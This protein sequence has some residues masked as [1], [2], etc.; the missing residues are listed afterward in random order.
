MLRIKLIGAIRLSLPRPNA[1][2]RPSACS[3]RDF[4]PL[5]RHGTQQS[6]R[7]L[8]GNE[9]DKE[10]AALHTRLADFLTS[11]DFAD[12]LVPEATPANQGARHFS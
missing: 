10:W 5:L 6:E 12:W 9:V 11:V 4:V 3:I 2:L 1:S 7:E 8:D